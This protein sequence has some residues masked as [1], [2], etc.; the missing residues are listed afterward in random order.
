ME[1]ISIIRAEASDWEPAM[2]LAWKT[3]L[4]YEAGDYSREGIDN[5]LNFISDEKLFKMFLEG[6][7]VLYVAKENEKVVGLTSLRAGNHISLLFVDEAY[8]R[9]GIGRELLISIQKSIKSDGVVK[10]T[11]N[12]APFAVGFYERVGFMKVGGM[13]ETDGIIYQPMTI[14]GRV[15]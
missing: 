15:L 4:K 8:H 14:M 12:A 7:Y 10:M 11:V 5:F 6:S 3:F 13:L 2:E 1:N 9:K